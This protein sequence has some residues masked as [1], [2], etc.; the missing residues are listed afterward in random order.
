MVLCCTSF[1][2]ELAGND[3][4]NRGISLLDFLETLHVCVRICNIVTLG[5]EL[6][7]LIGCLQCSSMDC[8]H[9]TCNVNKKYYST[10]TIVGKLDDKKAMKKAGW[11]K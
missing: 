4:Y 3:I 11:G 7:N 5:V 8:A 9:K 10:Y 1:A 2:L 6:L